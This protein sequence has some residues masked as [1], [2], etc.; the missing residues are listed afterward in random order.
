MAKAMAWLEQHKAQPFFMYLSLTIPHANNEATRGTGNGQEVPDYGRWA[1]R[2]WPNPEK[3]FAEMITRLDADVA[4]R[5]PA[6]ERRVAK[7]R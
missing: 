3:G 7:P 6:F 1:G 5:D 4:S 2:D